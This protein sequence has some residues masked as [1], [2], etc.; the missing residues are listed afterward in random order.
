M[1][2]DESWGKLGKIKENWKSCE[3]WKNCE[4]CMKL[5]KIGVN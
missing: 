2:I 3:N 1:K 5:A 4:N